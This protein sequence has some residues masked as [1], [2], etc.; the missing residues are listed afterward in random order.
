[1]RFEHRQMFGKEI[2]MASAVLETFR[3]SS[4]VWKRTSWKR[5]IFRVEIDDK[6]IAEMLMKNNILTPNK[7]CGG[8]TK[9]LA[10]LRRKGGSS[11]P[12]NLL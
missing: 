6:K 3:T 9:C 11:L 5:R 4:D 8:G 10:N 1:M 2:E 7:S 12:L